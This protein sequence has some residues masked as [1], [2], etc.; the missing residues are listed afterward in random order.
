[1]KITKEVEKLLETPEGRQRLIAL[2][3]CEL[4][5]VLKDKPTLIQESKSLFE[6]IFGKQH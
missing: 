5:E 1:M 3:L 4:V 2:K 6:L